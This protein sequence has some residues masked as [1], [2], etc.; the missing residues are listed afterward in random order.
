MLDKMS[1][2]NISKT[3]ALLVVFLMPMVLL[4]Q[5]KDI[6]GIF[7]NL[8]NAAAGF[9]MGLALV[10]FIIG[11]VRFIATAGDDKSRADGKQMMIWGTV[12]LFAMVAVWGLVTI[13]KTTFFG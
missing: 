3:L 4:A 10:I 5:L 2:K 8:L 6:A 12:S 1:K 7:V 13:I 9:I 11:M